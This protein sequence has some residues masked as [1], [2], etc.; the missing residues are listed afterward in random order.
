MK[1]IWFCCSQSTYG[2][3][4]TDWFKYQHP[5]LGRYYFTSRKQMVVVNGSRSSDSHALSGVS[6]G[7]ILGPLLFLIHSW[8]LEELRPACACCLKLFMVYASSHP[9]W[10]PQGQITVGVQTGNYCSNNHLLVPT[11]I[12]THLC[13]ILFMRGT[14]FLSLL[15]I[16][17]CSVLRVTL[18]TI[19][20]IYYSIYYL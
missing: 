20:L 17:V 10:L 16:Y 19:V 5:G 9:I 8:N 3:A 15:L 11:H 14:C 7:S 12:Y 18:L 6:Q 2:K 13:Y 1:G 4:T